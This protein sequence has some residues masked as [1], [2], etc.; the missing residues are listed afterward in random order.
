MALSGI[1]AMAFSFQRSSGHL[2]L[3]R[4]VGG[5]S[6]DA[7]HTVGMPVERKSRRFWPTMDQILKVGFQARSGHPVLGAI[8]VLAVAYSPSIVSAASAKKSTKKA[9]N[10]PPKIHVQI[11]ENSAFFKAAVVGHVSEIIDEDDGLEADNVDTEDL[12]DRIMKTTQKRMRSI[13]SKPSQLDE[14]ANLESND[15]L[16]TGGLELWLRRVADVH[17]L[18]LSQKQYECAS[19]VLASHAV[20]FWDQYIHD[21]HYGERIQE[22]EE[23]LRPLL[24]ELIRDM[25][26]NPFKERY[27]DWVFD[28]LLPEVDKMWDDCRYI[29]T[30]DTEFDIETKTEEKLY[31]HLKK[32]VAYAGKWVK[33]IGGKEIKNHALH[34]TEVAYYIVE[35]L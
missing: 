18:N 16:L 5:S 13:L 1:N 28:Q 22:L 6:R 11:N 15:V 25:H 32:T 33:G 19:Q 14:A 4:R 12:H 9:K 3:Q 35:G 23:G 2:Q 7:I 31:F 26:D 24:L 20:R 8:Q 17:G 27:S 10:Q 30:I 34:L 29:G 21:L